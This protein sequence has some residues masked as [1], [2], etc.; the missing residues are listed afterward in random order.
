MWARLDDAILDNPKIIAAGPIG[1]LLHVAAIT[2][3][4]RNLTDGLIPKRRVST[5]VPL[6]SIGTALPAPPACGPEEDRFDPLDADEVADTLAMIGLWHDRGAYWELHDYLVYN[7]PRAKVLAD[8][9]RARCKKA[10]QR[11]SRGDSPGD[12]QGDMHVVPPSVPMRPVPV[13][14]PVP[15]SVPEP[16]E[17]T[18]SLASLACASTTEFD[19]FWKAYPRRIDKKKAQRA[20]TKLRPPP[21]KAIL[22]ALAWQREL[23]DWRKDSGAFVPYPASYLNGRRWED[24]PPSRQSCGISARTAGNVA[25]IA[26]GLEIT[27]P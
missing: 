15:G 2:W 3:C 10:K 12:T 5:L 11:V 26:R 25:A 23:P 6:D 19:E 21:L 20:W 22:D 4:A 7:P 13:P 14:V 17:E 9:E 8:R 18:L 16:K 27:R 1:L 24:E